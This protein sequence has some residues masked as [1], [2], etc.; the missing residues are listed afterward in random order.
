MK[1][2]ERAENCIECGAC[3]SQCPQKIDI[4]EELK[5]ARETIGAACKRAAAA[6]NK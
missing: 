5:V 4:P 6:E 3:V 1:P 2:Q